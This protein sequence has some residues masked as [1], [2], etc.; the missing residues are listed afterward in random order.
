MLMIQDAL[1]LWARE[2]VQVYKREVTDDLPESYGCF[3]IAVMLSYTGFRMGSASA[4]CYTDTLPTVL[5]FA[6]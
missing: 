3:V 1:T 5:I 4:S 6:R 2:R